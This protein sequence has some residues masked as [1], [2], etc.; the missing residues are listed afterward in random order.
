MFPIWRTS[1]FLK[2]NLGGCT[3]SRNIPAPNLKKGDVI[4]GPNKNPEKLLEVYW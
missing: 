3:E 1:S 2:E 4:H